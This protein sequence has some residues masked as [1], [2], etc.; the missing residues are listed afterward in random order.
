MDNKLYEQVEKEYQL[1]YNSI[2]QAREEK[3]NLID[4]TFPN[5][6]DF[7]V[8][9]IYRNMQLEWSLFLWD[10]LSIDVITNDWILWKEKV[11]NIK[12]VF[13]NDIDIIDFQNIREDI[14]Q[15]NAMYWIW[16]TVV[17]WF[18]LET[19]TPIEH[20]IDPLSVIPDP[21]NWRWNTM[22]FFW[23]E[24]R[25]DKIQLEVDDWYFDVDKIMYNTD[26]ELNRD[27]IT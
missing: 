12:K 4:K 26:S 19:N 21:K 2:R 9:L 3:R 5:S 11:E 15:H 13:K 6:K 20:S 18:D 25:V 23:I 22:R 8:D 17:D 27:K 10:S 1:W 24:R 16:I 7:R 14:I